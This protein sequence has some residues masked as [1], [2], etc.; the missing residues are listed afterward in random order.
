VKRLSGLGRDP[1]QSR[2]PCEAWR[3]LRRPV[4]G[5]E[6]G[7]LDTVPAN[8]NKAATSARMVG[9]VETGLDEVEITE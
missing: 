8:A 4:Y 3:A 5:Y 1:L 2:P 6:P 7:L 9:A